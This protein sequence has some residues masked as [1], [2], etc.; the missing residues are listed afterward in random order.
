MSLSRR[1]FHGFLLAFGGMSALSA[2]APKKTAVSTDKTLN[3]AQEQEPSTLNTGVTS[4]GPVTF[5]ATK[6]F[7]GLLT[8][9]FDGKPLPQLATQ[10]QVSEDGLTYRFS[11]RPGVRWHDGQPFTADDVAFSLLKVWR[12]YHGRGRTT[13]ANVVKVESPDPLTSVWTLSQPAPYLIS[14]LAASESTVLPRHLYESGDI[15]T[16]PHNVAPIGTG[17]FRFSAWDRGNRIVLTRNPDYWDKGHPRLDR[18]VVRFLPDASASAIALETGSV[19]LVGA[20]PFSEI[21][22]LKARPSLVVTTQAQ[23]YSPT[24]T[25]LEFNLERPALQDVRVRQ[26]IAH[27][28]DRDFIA[29]NVIGNAEVADSPVPAELTDFHASGLPAYPFDIAR[30]NALL[31]AAGVKRGADGVRLK[32]FIDFAGSQAM[33][34]TAASMRSTLAQAGIQLQARAQDQGEYINRV[35]TRGDFDLCMTGS[36]AGRDPAIGIQ[37]YYWSK[38]IKK[39]V[40]FSNGPH[41]RNPEVDRLLEAAQVELDPARRRQLYADFQRIAMTDLPY[42]PLFYTHAWIGA[43]KRVTGLLSDLNGLNGNFAGVAVG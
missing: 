41:Y 37:R 25:Q 17:P 3:F 40:A 27:A 13:F 2:C 10:W 21:A 35:Y 18:L 6:I 33:I 20:V 26:A 8:Y 14:C 16:N 34:R 24:W 28:I 7:D 15:L 39:G 31:D 11:L 19:D 5:T 1:E 38:N 23:S 36:G 42:L 22:R 12:E 29:R 4:A 43:N 9:D 32:L 30:A